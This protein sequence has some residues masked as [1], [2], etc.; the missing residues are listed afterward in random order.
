MLGKCLALA[1]LVTGAAYAQLTVTCTPAALPQL[2]GTP[3]QVTCSASGGT[4]PYAWS[5]S[6]GALPP[7]LAQDPGTGN[8]TGTL[9]DPAGPYGFTVTATDSTQP[10]P[11][12]G[13]QSYSGATVDPLTVSCTSAAGPVEAGVLYTNS[14]TAA[15]GTGPYSWTITGA[16][17]PPGLAIS[18]TG[19]PGTISYTPPSALASYQYSV[20]VADSSSSV[21][22]ASQAFSGAIAAAV[23]ITTPSTLPPGAVGSVYSQQFAASGGVS[24]F[25]WSATGLTGTGL[26]MSSGGLLSGTPNAAGAISL[27]VTVDDAAGGIGSGPFSLTVTPQLTI[28]TTSPL[29]AATVGTAYSETLSAS[30]GSGTGY[31]WSLASGSLPAGLSLNTAGVIQGIPLTSAI[32]ENVTVKVVDSN[33][34][35][36]SA[37]FT[38]PVTLAISTGSPLPAAS[39]GTAYN[40]ALT[41]VGG[42]GGY[43]WSVTTGSLPAGLS[44][45]T[46]G[47]I[48]GIPLAGAVNASFTVTVKDSNNGSV[49]APFALPVTL[50]ITT[51]SPLPVAVIGTAYQQMLAAEGGAG[52]Y[53]WSASG[54]PA[55]LSLS[56]AGLISGTPGVAAVTST[57]N[58]TVTDS[59]SA[60][61][62][63]SFTLPVAI[64][65]TT[66]SPL[67]NGSV[68]TAYNQTLAGQGG[69]LPYSW[70]LA[71]G[72]QPLPGGLTL[73]PSGVISGNPSGAG[74]YSFTVQLS[75]S[76]TPPETATKAFVITISGPLNIST[77]SLPNAEVSVAYSQTLAAGGGT[78]PYTWSPV[79]ALPAPL[80]ALSL[81][82]SGAITG[83]PTASGAG[84]FKVTVTD[85]ASTAV[86]VTLA[87]TIVAA[88][89]I[90]TASLPNGSVGTAYSQALSASGGTPPY[91]WTVASGS[92]PAG[93]SLSTAGVI[94]G[95]PLTAGVASFTVQ[96]TDGLGVA[97]SKALA[98][99]VLSNITI[100]TVSPLP[101]G[102][103]SI[104]YSAKLAA[105]G[106]T[107]PYTWSVTSGA[108]PPGLSLA[109]SG[110]ITGDPSSAGMYSFTVQVTD[111]NHVVATAPFTLTIASFLTIKTS[112]TLASGSVG[113]PYLQG[114]IASAGVPPYVWS[115]SNASLPPGLTLAS[116]GSLTGVP[117]T[118]GTYNFTL[119]VEDAVNASATRQFTIIVG[120]GLII[121]SSP[122]LPAA[123]VGDAYT[124]SLQAAGG[125]A[126]YTWAIIAG[127]APPGLSL[128]QDGTLSGTPAANGAFTFT[129]QVVD[130]ASHSANEQMSLTVSPALSITTSTLPGAIVGTAYSQTLAATGGTAPYSWSIAAGALPGGLSFSAAGVINGTPN[131]AGTFTFTVQVADSLS[132]TATK[133]LQI[134][135][136]GGI[137]I[138]TA[139]VLPDAAVNESYSQTLSAAGGV[140]PYT[141]AVT[142]GSLPAGLTLS[143]AGALTGKPSA[144]GTFQLTV[145]VMDNAQAAA[146]QQFTL[147]VANALTITTTALPGGKTGAAYSQTLAATGGVPPYA[148]SVS[149]GTLP[150]G[151]SLSS[152]ILAGTPTTPGS[153]TFTIAVTDSA[154]ATAAQQ[155]TITVGGLVVTTT[156]SLPPAAVGTAY[157]QTIVAAGTPPYTWAITSGALPGGLSLNSASG[158]VSGTP[159]ASGSF[160]IT[161][162]VTDGNKSTA[163]QTL[164]LNVISGSFNGLA[165]TANAA[166]QL[167]GAL[168]L[169][170]AYPAPVSGQLTLTFLPDASLASPSD[171][172]SIQFSG[173]G[174]TLSFSIPANSTS[175]ISFELQTGTVA[176]TITLAVTWQSGGVTLPVPAALSQTIQ[177]APAV[178][179]ITAISASTT[180]SGFQV[181]IT[182]YS[183]TRE[184]SQATLQFTAAAGQTLQT[185]SLTVP[186][187]SAAAA[188]FQGST[189]DQYGSQF[190]LTLP[191]TVSNGA[192][193]AIASAS[194]QL[195]NSQGASSS[196]SASF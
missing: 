173:G 95:T 112:A 165:S 86:S 51:A 139:A 98:L 122:I 8:I 88:P 9:A 19:N 182:G 146:S 127:S 156:G 57:F 81:S 90:T 40:Q 166:E 56:T 102:E 6:A 62:P 49:S 185:P 93:L 149:T 52:G 130:S 123:A 159:T 191:F 135:I 73:G 140:A 27:S 180:S 106:G 195:V 25:S 21:L 155:L 13:S 126:P 193:S 153:Y 92:L 99:T 109:A 178:P 101:T 145:T 38:L 26:S 170:A 187:T 47:V 2:V 94:G 128:K 35:S 67:A 85:S 100:S 43:A 69:L 39:I 16:S 110:A 46:G 148:F 11:L 53:T 15:G 131:A 172:P 23:T 61:V 175:P 33:N 3:V 18:P 186:L 160:N 161:V 105:T 189:S 125:T 91:N 118:A 137:S 129:I 107:A 1:V 66:T 82:S 20:Q 190:I 83:T 4:S 5:I 164:S 104:P 30:G 36:A 196:A 163:S 76:A 111:S 134:T 192:A 29:P 12:T 115:L 184:L 152:A 70:S 63:K 44:L 117:V 80:A 55:G 169:G 147:V 97:A 60:T 32:T 176:G 58:V 151:I 68:G 17:I 181:V 10:T 120:T 138:T 74:I 179:A 64:S 89:S 96:L 157:S 121:S 132:V 45:T 194:V 177:T 103:I 48:S 37:A 31:S 54:L 84:S 59:A 124:Y 71:A 116:S 167:S 143:A 34:N 168:A 162:Q 119:A 24:P 113:I 78:P 171:D 174:R 114:L 41:A 7:S 28:S 75:D 141:W 133:Q 144:A 42:A 150:P 65:I 14:C 154:S 183:N 77:T 158:I 108:P 142:A 72:S 22:T 50:V 87:L 136:T 79:G 188:W